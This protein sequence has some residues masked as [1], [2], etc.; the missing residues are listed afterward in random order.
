MP[1]TSVYNIETIPLFLYL[2]WPKRVK[3]MTTPCEM[4]FLPLLYVVPRNKRPF[5]SETKLNKIVIFW[6]KIWNFEI[7]P[8]FTWS[9]PIIGSKL[10]TDV[11]IEFYFPNDPC[12]LS[13][14]HSYNI[15]IRGSYFTW[16]WPWH[17]NCIKSM[18]IWCLLHPFRNILTRLVF[19]AKMDDFNPWPGLDLSCD[20]WYILVN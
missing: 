18:F 6:K 16:P 11:T 20:F 10:T 13:H 7:Q 14:T 3:L 15:F 5:N 4:Q 19:M 2:Q 1:A 9:W 17:L 12:S 8:R